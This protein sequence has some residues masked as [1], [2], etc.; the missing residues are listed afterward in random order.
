MNTGTKW[1]A[2]GVGNLRRKSF[3]STV[4]GKQLWGKNGQAVWGKQ[5]QKQNFLCSSCSATNHLFCLYPNPHHSPVPQ[6][7]FLLLFYCRLYKQ[8]AVLS[9]Y[10]QTG[11]VCSTFC[12]P[13]LSSHLQ[14]YKTGS[15]LLRVDFILKQEKQI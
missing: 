13:H 7:C 5:W 14:I 6:S 3:I 12:I 15:I 10:L 2:Q 8:E 4:C 9:L 1:R 11:H